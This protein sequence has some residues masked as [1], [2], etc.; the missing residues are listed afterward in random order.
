MTRTILFIVAALSAFGP[1][2]VDFYLPSFP[3]MA[4][5]FSTDVGNIQHSLSSYFIGLAIGQIIYGPLSD[6]F[7]RRIPML[8]GVGLFTL[9]SLACALA[10]DLQWLIGLRFVQA[11]GGCAGMVIGRAITRDLCD[12][13]NS[14]KVFS[15][16]ML[17]MGAAPMLAPLG[18]ALLLEQFGWESI[19][20]CLAVFSGCCWVAVL[21]GLPET[22]N[23]HEPPAPLRGA[24]KAYGRLLRDKVFMG[25][26]FSGGMALSAKFAY[27][28]GS[29]FVFIELFELSPEQYGWLF[30]ANAAGFVLGAQLNSRLLNYQSPDY[31]LIRVV[32][33]FILCTAVPLF[34][35]LML[36]DSHWPILISLSLA[37]SVL[38][39]LT[40]NAM[41]GAMAAHGRIAGSASALMGCL[42]FSLAALASMMVASL[43]DGSAWPMLWVIFGCALLSLVATK[44]T[45]HA[46]HPSG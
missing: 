26:V 11:L 40:P 42:Q 15:Q 37:L 35:L 31:W 1:L 2:A 32:W 39:L 22:L 33:A 24:L 23:P 30:G 20:I 46:L 27:I 43:H 21:V 17:I 9:T 45:Q 13:I 14:A 6:R 29:P 10:S 38:G 8:V 12:P 25:Y 41:V 7:G 5:A 28:S 4:T 44:V 3:A 18:G 34:S 36:P 19:F 16:L